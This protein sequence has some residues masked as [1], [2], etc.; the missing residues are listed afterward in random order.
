MYSDTSNS[1][2]EIWS[3]G[4]ELTWADST[5]RKVFTVFFS[6]SFFPFFLSLSFVFSLSLF[7]MHAWKYRFEPV[8]E[9]WIYLFQWSNGQTYAYSWL[10]T[11]HSSFYWMRMRNLLI[12]LKLCWFGG[13]LVVMPEQHLPVSCSLQAVV[14]TPN[15]C[16]ICVLLSEDWAFEHTQNQFVLYYISSFNICCVSTHN[17]LC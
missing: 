12:F 17:I 3:C 4:D 16:F 1:G 7:F 6:F 14:V 5:D 10:K 9:W 13:S 11:K 2:L 15:V 8:V